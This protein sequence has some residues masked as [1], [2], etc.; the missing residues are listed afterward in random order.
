M[1]F[2]PHDFQKILHEF[3]KILM[4]Y[5][6]K[7]VEYFPKV[8]FR[9]KTFFLENFK[10]YSPYSPTK[11]ETPIYKGFVRG[12]PSRDT[13]QDSHPGTHHLGEFEV[14]PNEPRPKITVVQVTCWV[15][16]WVSVRVSVFWCES[17]CLSAFQRGWVSMVRVFSK[18]LCSLLWT[19]GQ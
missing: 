17:L 11:R 15:S 4:E 3:W 19:V 8:G 13:H 7:V 12:L 5:F 16:V 1:L 18:M 14:R 6:A 9:G 10:T 2:L